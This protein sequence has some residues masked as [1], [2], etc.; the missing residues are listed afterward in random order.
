MH[1]ALGHAKGLSNP[2]HCVPS[3]GPAQAICRYLTRL[4]PRHAPELTQVPDVLPPE[5][6]T[7]RGAVALSIEH[8]CHLGI[9][10][11]CCM[12]LAEACLQPIT[13]A[14]CLITHPESIDVVHRARPALP[15]DLH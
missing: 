8:H 5:R 12:Q 6:P 1:R 14:V 15:V 11:S 2:S 10:L 7:T 13:P 9:R 4:L 3:I